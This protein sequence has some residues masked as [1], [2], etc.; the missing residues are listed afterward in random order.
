MR[1]LLVEDDEQLADLVRTKLVAQQYVV[2][3]AADGQ[4]GWELAEAIAYDLILLDVMLPKLDG[5]S[6]CRQLRSKGSQA[7]VLLLTARAAVDDKIVG[8]DAG[9]DDYLVKPISLPEL[10]ARIRALLRRRMA[11][12]T[13][14]LEWGA[15][16]L[17]VD[18]HEITYYTTPLTLTAK[19]YAFLEL[20]LR[21]SQHIFSQRAIINQLWS[22]ES[23]PPGEETVRAH[24]KRLRQKLKTVGAEDLIETVYGL[25]YRLNQAFQLKKET[26]S[27]ATLPSPEHSL[28]NAQKNPKEQI[29]DRVLVI[30]QGTRFLLQKPLNRDVYEDACRECHKLIGLLGMIGLPQGSELA[31][32]IEGLFQ[33]EPLSEAQ[34]ESLTQYVS[35]LRDLIQTSDL[36]NLDLRPAQISS[37]TGQT[38][39]LLIVDREQEFI[40]GLMTEAGKRGVQ[41]AIASTLSAAQESIQRVRPDIVVIDLAQFD[42]QEGLQLLEELE[43]LAIPALVLTHNPQTVER[44]EIS[45]RQGRGFLSKPIAAERV[46][47]AIAL[48]STAQAVKPINPSATKIMV[49]DDDRMVLRLLRVVLEPWGLQIV[50][51]EHSLNFWQE[52]EAAQPDF[53][54]LDVNLPDVN[55]IELC[56]ALRNDA[57]W[58]WLPILFLTGQQDS[59]TMQKIFAAGADDYACKPIIAPEL[60]TRILNRLERVRVLRQNG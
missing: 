3:V 16:Q 51:L 19:E 44:V 30:E 43:P 28:E 6:F 58:S 22:L 35:Q 41:T 48:S 4:E 12:V 1:I 27:E 34:K 21:N 17:N 24:V 36:Q 18:T 29:L 39:R 32:Q 38:I 25:G 10:T 20:F 13:S 5:V 26:K 54:I 60:V 55:G 23:D 47:E 40:D 42:T 33:S 31:R 37:P 45:R 2:D 7:L 57:L 15:L 11:T 53:L 52:L 59:E 9:A 8:L 46:L 49:L 50:T 14:V 56:H